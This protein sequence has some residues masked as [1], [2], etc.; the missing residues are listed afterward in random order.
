MCI[1]PKAETQVGYAIKVR[2][3]DYAK[4]QKNLIEG[5]WIEFI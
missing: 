5:H 1:R 2:G 4:F 3:E